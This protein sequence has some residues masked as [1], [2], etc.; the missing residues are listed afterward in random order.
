MAKSL[1]TLVSFFWNCNSSFIECNVIIGCHLST[2]QNTCSSRLA[3]GGGGGEAG[4]AL[5]EITGL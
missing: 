5:R 3:G 1:C 2:V 4:N